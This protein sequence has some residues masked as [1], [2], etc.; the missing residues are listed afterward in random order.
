MTSVI[1]ADDDKYTQILYKSIFLDRGYNV[2]VFSDSNAVVEA[3][4][5][6]PADLLILDIHMP[7]KSG[8][9]LCRELR[10]NAETFNV[11]IILVSAYDTED[12]IVDGLSAGADDYIIKP[13]KLAELLAKTAAVIKKRNLS[14]SRGLGIPVG[15]LFAGRYEVVREIGS[16]GFSNVYHAKDTGSD[17]PREVALK[18]FEVSA[19][20]QNDQ[21]FIATFLRE[22]YGLSKL[23]NP[24]IVKLYDFGHTGCY[25]YLVM[26]YLEGKTLHHIVEDSGAMEEE[27]VALI[28]YEVGKALQHL[29]SQKIVHRDIKPIN[30]V[31]VA[32][33]SVKLI[34]F[35]L[36]RNVRDG[37][38][39]IEGIFKGTPQ[40]AAPEVIRMEPDIGAK[41][42]IY[43]LGAT[44]YYALT[45][46]NPF[47]GRTATEVFSNRFTE[48]PQPVLD[49]NDTISL[50]FSDLIDRMLLH[51]KTERPELDEIVSVM[52]G[53]L[54]RS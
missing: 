34:D 17:R 45:N 2:R 19:S 1:C 10:K 3:Q 46:K 38:I 30:I 4:K 50:T 25:Y 48:M 11:P 12:V 43:S 36:A 23:D 44:L 24:N 28:A 33:G 13:F 51:D 6:E 53:I 41:A 21:E 7:G 31:V 47:P 9:D 37:K 26:E 42:D 35:G 8:L 27:D 52:A 32:N 18:I 5:K 14:I 22:A 39:T 49:I 54:S 15:C 20:M 29:E 40:F 16:G